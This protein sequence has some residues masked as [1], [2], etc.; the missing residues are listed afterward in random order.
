M[1]SF[2]DRPPGT[3]WVPAFVVV[4]EGFSPV[5]A[6]WR[7]TFAAGQKPSASITK[8]FGL[9]RVVQNHVSHSK[10][11]RLSISQAT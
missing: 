5:A 11:L 9:R 4:A 2:A 1:H 10:H 6:S 3:L 8:P 7:N